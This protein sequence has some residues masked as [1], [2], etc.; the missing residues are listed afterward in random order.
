VAEAPDEEALCEDAPEAP[1]EA[2][3]DADVEPLGACEDAPDAPDEAPDEA[4]EAPEDACV[5]LLGNGVDAPEAADEAPD[6]LDDALLGV[7]APDAPEAPEDPSVLAPDDADVTPLAC[8]DAP[9]APD[10]A[11][12][13]L[14]GAREDAPEA[15]AEAPDDPADALLGVVAP[16]AADEDPGSPN[17]CDW[18]SYTVDDVVNLELLLYL[19]EQDVVLM[20][21]HC[22]LSCTIDIDFI[23]D[24]LLLDT[25]SCHPFVLVVIVV[26]T[27]C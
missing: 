15:A 11:E 7:V 21:I 27:C 1:E 22:E 8:E 20:I 9:E 5:A 19:K 16:L 12:V 24:V 4:P 26:A 3:E 18:Y 13:A 14:L 2:L 23:T 6:A 10:D 25:I 17:V